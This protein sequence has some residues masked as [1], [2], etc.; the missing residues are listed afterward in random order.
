LTRRDKFL[1]I[2]SLAA[3]LFLFL[4]GAGAIPLI[5]PDE[6]R[7]SQVARQMYESG[8]YIVPR[9]G[10]FPWFEKPVLLY[11]FMAF[12]YALFGINEFAARFPSALTALATVILTA[13]L[14]TKAT[15]L[16]RGI[17][18][19]I[20]LG[21]C[22]FTIGFSH[23]ATFDMLL[24]ATIVAAFTAFMIHE[25]DQKRTVALYA[26]YIMAGFAV[27]AKGFVA[28]I[29]I[30][31]AIGCYYVS[32]K[33]WRA[34]PQL[35]P[36]TGSLLCV[37]VMCI[38]FLPITWLYGSYFWHDFFLQHHFLRYTSS[39]YHQS[40]GPLFYLP[41]LLVGTFPWTLTP[42]LSFK[43][44]ENEKKRILVRFALCWF[45]STVLF[46]SFSKSKLPGYVLPAI[47]A[48]AILGGISLVDFFETPSKSRTRLVIF[49]LAINSLMVVAL[50]V[51][52]T[53]RPV[54]MTPLVVMAVVIGFSTLLAFLLVAKNKLVPAIAVYS[55]IAISE[56][57]LTVHEVPERLNWHESKSLSA[58]IQP[59]LSRGTKLALYNI[60]DFSFVFYTNGRVELTPKGYFYPMRTYADLHRY[61]SQKKE[62]LV[63]VSNE[64]LPWIQTADFWKV[65]R[66]FRGPNRSV[67]QIT[68][69]A[70]L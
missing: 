39:Y 3:L 65:V 10:E 16:R 58:E 69:K 11:W 67:V 55:L 60:Y 24:T 23:A 32:L 34:L 40:G 8:D 45:I 68:I 51:G 35:K 38:W 13:F 30:A 20:I 14:V 47:P 41:V 7:Y 70:R 18:S 48:F 33:K 22:I 29:L 49:V 42:L 57:L 28:L 36:V 27:L 6:P 52:G 54:L 61:A 44:A 26:L 15:D 43:R 66:I 62:I 59:V 12:S 64:E 17:T 4:Y 25:L 1:L 19:A 53:T 9:M 56:V 5:S 46:F 37:L 50:V 2:I 63:A 21:T 31:L